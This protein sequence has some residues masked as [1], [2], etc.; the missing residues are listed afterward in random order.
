MWG[1]VWGLSK[2]PWERGDA[3]ASAKPITGMYNTPVKEML[4]FPFL[5]MEKYFKCDFCHLLTTL[6]SRRR[7]KAEWTAVAALLEQKTKKCLSENN[8]GGEPRTL[9][10]F[11]FQRW[12]HQWQ[13]YIPGAPGVKARKEAS[14]LGIYSFFFPFMSCNILPQSGL[15]PQWFTFWG[16]YVI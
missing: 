1:G 15:W 6:I 10:G 14:V 2:P 3:S 8:L 12:L 9:S 5:Q 16:H 13:Q 11:Q 7:R 4:L